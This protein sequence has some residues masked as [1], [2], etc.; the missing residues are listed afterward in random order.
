M[1]LPL[2]ILLTVLISLGINGNQCRAQMNVKDTTINASLISVV[3]G[4][5]TPQMEMSERFLS[6]ISIG[7]SYMFKFSSNW[8]ITADANFFWRDTIK[9]NDIIDELVTSQN[10]VID[11]DGSLIEVLLLERGFNAHVGFGRI[12]LMFGPNPNSGIMLTGKLGYLQ[13][14]VHVRSL[15]L[16]LY[17]LT[18]EMKEGYD[19]LTSGVSAG[20]FLGYLFLGNN[21]RISFYGGFDFL[22]ARSVNRRGYNYDEMAYDTE[23]RNDALVGVKFGWIIPLYRRVAREYYVD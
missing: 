4:Y 17:S 20:G 3:I 1:K 15:G 22:Y 23:Y 12:F 21:R 2:F 6:S 13:H 10:R 16:N 19:R 8:I 7:A 11:R 18:D 9:T 14:K 5:Q